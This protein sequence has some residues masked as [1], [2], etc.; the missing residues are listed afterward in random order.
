[1][2]KHLL[3]ESERL[4]AVFETPATS[5]AAES[6]APAECPKCGRERALTQDH[7]LTATAAK[8]PSTAKPQMLAACQQHPLDLTT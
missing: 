8:L 7:R 5:I 1:M 3:E 6:L 2:V 4:L